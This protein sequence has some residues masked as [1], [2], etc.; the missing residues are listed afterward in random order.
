[1]TMNRQQTQQSRDLW[2]ERERD[3]YRL[4]RSRVRRLDQDDPR[5]AEAFRAYRHAQSWRKRRDRELAQMPIIHV[6]AKGRAD[7]I[8]EEGVRRWA[9]LDSAGHATFGVG[10]LIHEGGIRGADRRTW[11]TPARPLSMAVVDSVLQTDLV[12]FERAVA[13]VLHGTTW[14]DNQ[15]VFNVLVSFAFNIGEGGFRSST[16]A[17]QLRAGNRRAAA[18]AMLLWDLPPELRGRRER[19]RKRLLA[20]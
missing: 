11:G 13:E 3:A 2:R 20:A 6:D 8:R 4:W 18:D 19:E 7:I 9:Y 5:R 1:M 17:R 16:V 15:A 10:H 14:A 12:R